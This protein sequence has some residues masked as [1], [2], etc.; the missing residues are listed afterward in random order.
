MDVKPLK[1]T[2]ESLFCRLSDPEQ[3][4]KSRLIDYWPEIIGGYFSKHTKPQFARGGKVTVWVDD[5]TTAFKIL[6][7]SN[8]LNIFDHTVCTSLNFSEN[9]TAMD[10]ENDSIFIANRSNA[11]IRLIQDQPSQCAP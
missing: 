10:M 4:A 8:P 2:L 3:T 1:S 6:N 11:E 9:T 7:V 5:S